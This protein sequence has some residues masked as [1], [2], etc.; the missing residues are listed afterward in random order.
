MKGVIGVWML[1]QLLFILLPNILLLFQTILYKNS[2]LW[3]EYRIDSNICKKYTSDK[4]VDDEHMCMWEKL[5]RVK[6]NYKTI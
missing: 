3:E 5:F 4:S 1:K 2:K 6:H